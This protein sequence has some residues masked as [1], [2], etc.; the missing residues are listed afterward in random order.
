M[1]RRN[2]EPSVRSAS[3]GA[4]AH[5]AQSRRRIKRSEP[6]SFRAPD[7]S[8]RGGE[9]VIASG[10]ATRSHPNRAIGIHMQTSDQEG[11]LSLLAAVTGDRAPIIT[12]K[13]ISG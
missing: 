1:L 13:G 7:A 11:A 6:V 4:H 12:A 10:V 3:D 5:I 9:P 8:D 2:P